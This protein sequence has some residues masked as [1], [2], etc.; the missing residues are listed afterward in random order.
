MGTTSY[1]LTELMELWTRLIHLLPSKKL[2][3]H[4]VRE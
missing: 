2:T 4:R 3:A 1:T